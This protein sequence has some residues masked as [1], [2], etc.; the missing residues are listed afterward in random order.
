MPI[1]RMK[2]RSR[3]LWN[4]KRR[5]A[6]TAKAKPPREPGVDRAWWRKAC[7]E[8]AQV[9]TSRRRF[10]RRGGSPPPPGR[11]HA[12]VLSVA[13]IGLDEILRCAQ[14]DGGLRDARRRLPQ[15][16]RAAVQCRDEFS[17][18]REGRYARDICAADV[19]AM[20][21][22]GAGGFDFV[23]GFGAAAEKC[24]GAWRRAW[25][26]PWR[27]GSGGAAERAMCRDG[28]EGLGTISRR[29]GAVGIVV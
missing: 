25:R 1:R 27:R 6:R 29:F 14:N 17:F 23:F 28:A 15:R 4:R 12:W 3:L 19:G 16:A 18:C 5:Q 10:L 9:E 13:G 8:C 11:W 22:G 20:H 7:A 21:G 26:W 2:R 24:C